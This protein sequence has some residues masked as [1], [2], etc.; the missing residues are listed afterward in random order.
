MIGCIRKVL[1]VEDLRTNIKS[2]DILQI[3]YL[4]I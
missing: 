3:F 2:I 4:L 1:V